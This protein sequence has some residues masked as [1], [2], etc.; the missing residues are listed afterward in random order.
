MYCSLF[1]NVG[2]N[3]SPILPPNGKPHVGVLA[4]EPNVAI[5]NMLRENLQKSN[6]PNR[7]FVLSC[8]IASSLRLGVSNFFFYNS[9]GESSSLSMVN[10]TKGHRVFQ[11]RARFSPSVPLGPGPTGVDFVPTL[12]LNMILRVIP[13]DISIDYLK[14]DAQGYDLQIIQS[15]EASELRRIPRIA[16][17]VF[18]PE[19]EMDYINVT[20]GYTEWVEYM[21]SI[22]YDLANV[23]QNKQSGFFDASWVRRS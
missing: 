18:M 14:V 1:I 16:S 8:A 4:V 10:P 20:N 21:N 13:K 5:A 9:I 22:G 2:S 12:T 17:E 11:N 15:A 19:Q 6:F 23:P 7:F 3:K